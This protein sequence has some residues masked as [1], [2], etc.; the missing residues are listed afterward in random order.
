MH[1]GTARRPRAGSARLSVTSQSDIGASEGSCRHPRCAITFLGSPDLF[2][3]LEVSVVVSLRGRE[4]SE[5]RK[6][7]EKLPAEFL[8]VRARLCLRAVSPGI[9]C[10]KME[11]RETFACDLRTLS[12]GRKFYFDKEPTLKNRAWEHVGRLLPQSNFHR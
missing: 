2:T 3:A 6:R 1:W 9:R 8:G 11:S 4:D 10:A 5:K 7:R 12:L